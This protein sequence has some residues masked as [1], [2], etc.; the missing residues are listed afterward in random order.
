M[1][2]SSN[3]RK[4]LCGRKSS[5]ILDFLSPLSGNLNREI[6][7]NELQLIVDNAISLDGVI[8]RQESSFYWHFEPLQ[9][10][11]PF[12]PDLMQ[13]DWGEPVPEADQS[14][15]LVTAPALV[16]IRKQTGKDNVCLVEMAVSCTLS[17]PDIRVFS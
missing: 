16:K 1:G 4:V 11:V 15:D 14:V 17:S 13:P 6:L 2:K 3:E 9:Y 5:E 8:C 12:N 10:Q 7:L